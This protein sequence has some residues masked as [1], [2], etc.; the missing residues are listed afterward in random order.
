MGDHKSGFES[1]QG[2]PYGSSS[3]MVYKILYLGSFYSLYYYD[4]C[5][6][7]LFSIAILYYM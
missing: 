1:D 6:V 7:V 2:F 4:H 5:L 3:H